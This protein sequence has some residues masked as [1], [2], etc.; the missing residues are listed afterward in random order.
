VDALPL[1][2]GMRVLEIGC[3]PGAAAREIAVR[4]APGY[5]L[6]IDRSRTAIQQARGA[7]ADLLKAKRMGLRCVS[8]EDFELTDAEQRFDLAFAVRVGVLDGRHPDKHARALERIRA[9]LTKR[10]CLW[11]GDGAD[12]HK[13]AL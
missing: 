3:G 7:C 10:G 5:V 8:V 13:L 4:V 6:G 1:K 9:A 11:V 12:I 2:K